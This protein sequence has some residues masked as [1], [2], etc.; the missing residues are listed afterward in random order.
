MEEIIMIGIG[1]DTGGTYTD[2]VIYD[3]ENKQILESAKSLTTKS[4]LETGI[5]N[6]LEKLSQ[7]AL[8]SAS[9]MALSTT[10]ATNACVEG[11]GGRAKLVFIGVNPGT[12]D[13]TYLSYGLPPSR[14]IYF[15]D[16]D[17]A[18]A[19]RPEIKP[20]WIK[21]RQDVRTC[22]TDCDSIAVVQIHPK[23]NGAAYEKT[24][25]QII[26]E[27]LDVPC[28]TGYELFHDLNV[29]RRG[30]SAL[31]N[32]R[33]MPV[34]KEFFKAI[35]VS[36][37]NLGLSLPIVIV[38]SDG[39]LM[40]QGFASTRP[41]ETLLCGPAASVMGGVELADEENAL[42]VDMGG[43]TSD[44]A[45]VKNHTPV[46]VREGIQIGIYKTFVKGLYVDT[47]GLGGDSAIRYE[48]GRLYLD[49]ERVIPLCTLSSQFPGVLAQLEELNQT[50]KPHSHFLHEFFVLMK[51][52]R[53]KSSYTQVELD[54]CSA[55]SDGPLIF[56]KAAAA[57][58]KDTYNFSMKRLEQEG[59]VMRS[60]LT[61]TDIM[62]IR[63][64]YTPFDRKASVLGAEFI[65]RSVEITADRL[66]DKV[67]H[68]VKKKLY[69]NL[70]RILLSD[71]NST[72]HKHL[73]PDMLNS[74]IE[75]SYEDAVTHETSS[76]FSTQFQTH[77]TLI[78]VG[79]PI[80]IFL[81]DVAKLLGTKAVIPRN[82]AVAN[83]LGAVVGNVSASY[84]V[85]I[86][87]LYD[88]SDLTGYQVFTRS[89]CLNFK[90]YDAARETAIEEAL[91]GARSEAYQRGA[92][93]E[94]T[95]SYESSISEAAIG[96]N[97]LFLGEMIV[98]HAIGR[99][100]SL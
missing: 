52:P 14:E 64:D 55:L 46:T 85:E 91:D 74:L 75:E 48:N 35:K 13:E 24:A 61:P 90:D 18:D 45:I 79:A 63:K 65:A 10:L 36:L 53:N 96:E 54:F 20:D 12:V 19:L 92:V 71:H 5:T 11:K 40:S 60:G 30:A 27:E 51:E 97:N 25:L 89:G 3:L 49:T 84:D 29:L 94:I 47:F 88:S 67:Y 4:R 38:R 59:I 76:F 44:I 83:A 21:F 1:I 87:P 66:T 2:A 50:G 33:L 58:H 73:N 34:M 82:A 70:V 22:F 72:K 39:S 100:I 6:V 8:Q 26:T 7:T 99:I 81:E 9:F 23:D 15:M 80:H 28:I 69:C 42:I 57:I 17:P 37:E 31:L 95:T 43:T 32:A 56:T 16:G 98:G 93:G 62:H 78:G 86:K 68:L 77:A 41:V